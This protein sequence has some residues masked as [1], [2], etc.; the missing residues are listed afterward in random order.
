MAEFAQVLTAVDSE[1]RAG[2]ISQRL[3]EERLVACVQILGPVQSRYWWE[4]RIKKVPEILAL[5][6]AAGN[7]D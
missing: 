3:L 2:E 4:G 5:P 7:P 1:E 6:I